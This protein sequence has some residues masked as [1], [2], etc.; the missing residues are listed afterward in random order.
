MDWKIPYR[1]ESLFGTTMNHLRFIQKALYPLR[2]SYGFD[3]DI[4]KVTATAFDTKL[5][6]SRKSISKT[7]VKRGL[8]LPAKEA[9]RFLYDLGNILLSRDFSRGGFFD[10]S[11]RLFVIPFDALPKGF[12]VETDD[13]I[14]FKQRGIAKRYEAASVTDFPEAN[15]ILVKGKET[16]EEFFNQVH[17]VCV[18]EVINM[19]EALSV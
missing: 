10:V 11:D 8:V 3:F 6:R 2:R 13:Y 15:A 1:K 5:G 14:V 17:T 16:P 12:T 18:H 4:Y 7:P 19:E 9:T